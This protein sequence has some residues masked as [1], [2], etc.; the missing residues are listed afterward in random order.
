MIS[1]PCNSCGACCATFKVSFHWSETLSDSHAVPLHL[2]SGL[3][4]HRNTMLGTDSEDPRCIALAGVVGVSSNCSIYA[5][6]PDCCRSFAAS[7]ENGNQDLRCDQAR[8]K[9]GLKIL[10]LESWK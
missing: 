6:R 2:T 9:K 3:T 1:H 8:V 5:N 10:T 7:F 4:A